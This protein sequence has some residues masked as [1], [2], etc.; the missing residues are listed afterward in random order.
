MRNISHEKELRSRSEPS[1]GSRAG[2]LKREHISMTLKYAT[3]YQEK[4]GCSLLECAIKSTGYWVKD[5]WT[6]RNLKIDHNN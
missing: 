2:C 5:Q 6:D 1:P 4:S 3:S